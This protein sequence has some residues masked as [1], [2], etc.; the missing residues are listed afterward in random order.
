M[1]YYAAGE[2]VEVTLQTPDNGSY[3]E[4]TVTVTLGQAQTTQSQNT[5]NNSENVF[6]GMLHR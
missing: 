5:W 3:T 4:K 6:G 1:Q 2:S